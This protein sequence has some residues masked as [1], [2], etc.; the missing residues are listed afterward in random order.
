VAEHQP[1]ISRASLAV[2]FLIEFV[3]AELPSGNAAVSDSLLDELAAVAHGYVDWGMLGDSIR[4][5]LESP[6]FSILPSG[7]V[8][9]EGRGQAGLDEFLLAA[10]RE[11]IEDDIEERHFSIGSAQVAS[12]ATGQA[13]PGELE[14]AFQAEWSVSPRDLVA[15]AMWLTETG[16][17]LEREG[18]PPAM[19]R[20]EAAKAA[21]L[22]FEL[23]GG[24]VERALDMLLLRSRAAWDHIPGGLDEADI[25]P[26]RY[27]RRL[28][29]MRRPVVLVS[30]DKAGPTDDVIYWGPRQVHVAVRQFIQ[31]VATGRFRVEHAQS[32][33]MRRLRGTIIDRRGKAFESKVSAWA[34][35]LAGC[36][37]ESRVEIGPGKTLEADEDLGD[38][39]VL[40]VDD[41]ARVIWCIEAKDIDFGRNPQEMAQE[42]RRLL[43]VQDKEQKKPSRAEMH[44]RRLDW[45]LSHWRVVAD[46]F[47]L[48]GQHW[49]VVG[50][51]ASDDVLP[52]PYLAESPLPIL[53][54][55][56]L[57][58]E[59]KKLLESVA[60]EHGRHPC[61]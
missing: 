5:R 45:I 52:S 27:N 11:A 36:R 21:A 40:I 46:E 9:T 25:L 6:A 29:L 10:S 39:D 58:R 34:G 24:A 28:S 57:A 51:L 49:S 42:M 20:T 61:A 53:P 7:R 41:A 35:G 18:R 54:F 14:S 26:Y 1:K 47:G 60:A 15:V 16:I 3:A 43:P 30:A 55:G 2:R 19:P 23:N 48:Q 56:R 17:Q 22:A 37:Y 59:G 12:G 13:T 50:L 8:G 33:A 31:L 44:G 38:V 4:C 32:A